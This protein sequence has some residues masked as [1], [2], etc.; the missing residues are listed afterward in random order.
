MAYQFTDSLY[1]VVMSLTSGTTTKTKTISGINSTDGEG[2][3]AS[4]ALIQQFAELLAACVQGNL[5]AVQRN[6]RTNIEEV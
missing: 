4:A 6:A 5:S 3:T 1:G 2:A